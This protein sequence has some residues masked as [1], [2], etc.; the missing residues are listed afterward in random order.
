M[1]A[2]GL[3]GVIVAVAVVLGGW[4][5]WD[6]GVRPNLFPKNFGVVE[7][8]RLY[9]SGALTPAATRL[10]HERHK[11]KTI[12][13][14]G[15]YDK[16]PAGERVAQRTAEALGIRRFAFRLEGD[17]TGN[18]NMYVEALRIITDP[19]NAP[20]LV[21]CAAGAQR[22]GGCVVLYRTIEQGVSLD[23]AYGET[24]EYGHSPRDN[25]KLKPYLDEWA[26]RIAESV[27]TGRPIPG[28]DPAS[29]VNTP[30]RSGTDGE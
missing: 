28:V 19:A 22:T 9:R 6:T 29:P 30:E 12:V 16:D 17:G 5:A 15:A 7:P 26:A 10:V 8:G 21:H 18:P 11:I 4:T 27:R 3:V 24:D 23:E 14:L 25:P 1:P 20:V 13:D 2:R